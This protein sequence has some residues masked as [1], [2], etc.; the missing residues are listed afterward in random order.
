LL[1]DQSGEYNRVARF[2][3]RL[4][5]CL[6][7]LRHDALLQPRFALLAEAEGAPN[8]WTVLSDNALLIAL[9]LLFLAAIIGVI[10]QQRRRDRCLKLLQ[11]YH[12]SWHSKLGAM[13]WGD[14]LVFPKALELEFDTPYEN[15][16]GIVKNSALLYQ[17]HFEA[18][19]LL[20]RVPDGLSDDETRQRARQMR[21]CFRPGIVRRLIRWLRNLLFTL[22]DA[23]AQA[24]TLILGQLAKAKPDNTVLTQERGQVEKIG[25]TLLGV[26]GNAFEAIL[27]RHIGKQ[28][29]IRMK[30][31]GGDAAPMVELVGALAEYTAD[32]YA[33]FGVSDKP[34]VDQTLHFAESGEQAGLNVVRSAGRV[35]I[36]VTDKQ[37][38]VLRA[39]SS[40][41]E[42]L[43]LQVAVV[44]GSRIGLALVGDGPIEVVACVPPA[45]DVVVPRVMSDVLFG[46]C[47]LQD[48]VGQDARKRDAKLS[49]APSVVIE[50]AN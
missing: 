5:D 6:F 7:M 23:M 32:F 48:E 25:Q 50:E 44:P 39:V 31:P 33:V 47:E 15:S 46:S 42:H 14:L 17:A 27:E 11:D 38:H 18:T 24:M 45:V 4:Q 13:L 9:F 2:L 1:K 26:G 40:D 49:A 36:T 34:V 20:V 10:L 41:H 3:N 30:M 12:V 19:Q 8:V 35:E 16:K 21:R 22:R 37:I 43:D 28:V 29:V